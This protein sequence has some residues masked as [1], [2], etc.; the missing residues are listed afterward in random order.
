MIFQNLGITRLGVFDSTRA[1]AWF[2]KATNHSASR[3]P[4]QG[5]RR[6]NIYEICAKQCKI[7][8]VSPF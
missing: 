2:E 8:S 6:I 1:I 7:K 4:C 5:Y 3:C